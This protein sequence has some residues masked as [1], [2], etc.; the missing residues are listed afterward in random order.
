MSARQQWFERAVEEGKVRDTPEARAA[1]KR[2]WDEVGRRYGLR[3][4]TAGPPPR[5]IDPEFAWLY[6]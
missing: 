6:E 4:P 2:G 1:H 5:Q 3:E